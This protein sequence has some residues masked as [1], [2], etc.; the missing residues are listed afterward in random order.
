MLTDHPRSTLLG[1]NDAPNKKNALVAA[2]PSKGHVIQGESMQEHHMSVIFCAWN[3]TS[4]LH[5]QPV[6]WFQESPV[7]KR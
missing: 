3:E 2:S 6:R 5:L 1:F 7:S 4:F